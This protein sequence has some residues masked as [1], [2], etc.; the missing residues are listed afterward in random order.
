LKR[1][2]RRQVYGCQEFVESSATA[3]F[4]SGELKR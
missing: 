3:G 4:V 1:C 2:R